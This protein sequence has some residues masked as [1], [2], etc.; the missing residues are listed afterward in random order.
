[1]V[2]WSQALRRQKTSISPFEQPRN[3]RT[4]NF[5]PLTAELFSRTIYK[6]NAVHLEYIFDLGVQSLQVQSKASTVLQAP[7]LADLWPSATHTISAFPHLKRQEQH[8]RVDIQQCL[9]TGGAPS[10][11]HLLI[12]QFFV[13]PAQPITSTR[14]PLNSG[15]LVRISNAMVSL[16]P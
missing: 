1:M 9:T 12:L 7:R 2:P 14:R 6:F 16:H 15:C 8:S 4:S 3:T 11:S 5:H 13:V 10:L